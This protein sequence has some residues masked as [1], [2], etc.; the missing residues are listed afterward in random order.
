MA[1]PRAAAALA[2]PAAA[3]SG[4]AAAALADPAAAPADEADVGERGRR[5]VR[6]RRS[7]RREQAAS[8]RQR[9]RSARREGRRQR[10]PSRARSPSTAVDGEPIEQVRL[11]L[12]D[13]DEQ[14][15]NTVSRIGD[16]IIFSSVEVLEDGGEPRRGGAQRRGRRH[17]ARIDERDL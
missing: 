12:R 1:A 2:D 13:R 17:D 16:Q 14:V 3:A 4:A 11:S 8:S 15:L 9:S 10:Q 5:R 7:A 6:I